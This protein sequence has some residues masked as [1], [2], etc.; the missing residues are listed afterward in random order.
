MVDER[1]LANLLAFFGRLSTL[2][3]GFLLTSPP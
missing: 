3:V 2:L 1:G